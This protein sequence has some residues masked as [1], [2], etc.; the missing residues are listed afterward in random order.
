M[1]VWGVAGSGEFVRGL[2]VWGGANCEHFLCVYPALQC[3]NRRKVAQGL[4]IL[5]DGTVKSGSSSFQPWQATY[6]EL[7]SFSLVRGF[8]DYRHAREKMWFLVPKG[9]GAIF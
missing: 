2:R 7:I 9:S 4:G 3:A 1:R 5:R 6:P 8:R